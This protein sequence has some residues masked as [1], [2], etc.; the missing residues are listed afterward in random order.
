MSCIY[1]G[2]RGRTT[3]SKPGT[4][5][6][7]A[8]FVQS[9]EDPHLTRDEK[10]VVISVHILAHLLDGWVNRTE[11]ACIKVPPHASTRGHETS[12]PFWLPAVADLLSCLSLSRLWWMRPGTTS[13]ASTRSASTY[14]RGASATMSSSRR[15]ICTTVSAL[16]RW[17]KSHLGIGLANCGTG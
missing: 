7:Q 17:W 6:N 4:L 5:D 11:M 1:G 12:L 16:M 3:L 14:W 15:R 8:D 9:M 10:I 13:L 2:R